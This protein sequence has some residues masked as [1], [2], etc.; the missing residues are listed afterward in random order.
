MAIPLEGHPDERLHRRTTFDAVTDHYD[1]GRPGYPDQLFAD[2]VDQTGLPPGAHLLE[3]GPG[4]GHATLP[5]AGRGYQID[6]WE[7]GQNLA[8]RWR[9]N[10]QKFPNATITVGQFEEAD[11]PTHAYDLAYAASAFHWIEPDIGF[12][13]VADAL[14]PGG[15]LALWWNRNAAIPG[16]DDFARVTRSIYERHAPD[17]VAADV[18]L[19]DPPAIPIPAGNRIAESGRFGPV[20][21]RRYPFTREYDT[22]T[23]IALF[24]SFSRYQVLEVEQRQRLFDELRSAIDR[25]LSGKVTRGFTSLLYMAQPLSDRS[26]LG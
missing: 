3:I 5:F 7:L 22:E 23:L 8:G 10:L 19:P 26:R 16:N 9:E 4:T 1:R 21:E 17:L 2:V 20:E 6:A 14:K 13:K 12:R 11:L 15:W 25:D 18:D 24:D